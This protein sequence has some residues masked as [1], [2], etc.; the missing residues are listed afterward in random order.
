METSDVV[1]RFLGSVGSRRESDF[2]LAL[3]RAGDPERFAAISVDA[4]VARHAA[5][6]VTLDLRFLAALGL[7]PVV[8]LGLFESTEALEQATRL[9]RR[10]DKAGVRAVLLGSDEPDLMERAADRKSVV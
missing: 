5:E 2:Y 10:L 9:A 4:N 3:F 7:Y 8:L 1:L 6:A